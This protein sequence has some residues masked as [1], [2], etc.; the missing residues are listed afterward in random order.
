MEGASHAGFKYAVLTA[1]ITMGTLWDSD[2]ALMG[3]R[4]SLNGKDLIGPYGACRKYN[5]KV[6]STIQV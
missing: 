4:Q 6:D 5:M 1:D 3:V 2:W